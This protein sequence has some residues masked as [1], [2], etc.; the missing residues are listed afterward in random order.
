MVVPHTVELNKM[1]GWSV[2]TEEIPGGLRLTVVAVNPDD[3]KGLKVRGGSR[4][5]DMMLKQAGASVISLP[6]NEIYAAM[7]TGSLDAAV[8]SST[9][10]ISFRLQEISKNVTSGRQGSF[11]FMFEPLIISKAIFDAL[12]AEQQYNPEVRQV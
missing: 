4:E 6:S 7:Q 1:P 8:T 9:S 11:W 2:Q 10:L 12:P 5:M 3:A